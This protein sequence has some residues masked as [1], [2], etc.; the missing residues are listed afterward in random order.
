MKIGILGTRGIPNHYGGFEQFTEFLSDGL[1][2]KGHEVVVYNSSD[3]PYQE[4]MWNGV[5]IQHCKDWEGK[6]GTVG[7]FFYDL[8]CIRNA[9]KQ[10]FDILLQ[11]GYTS[12]SVWKNLLPKKA[13]IVTN[14]DG[15]EWKRSKFSKPV[16]QFL[17]KAEKWAIE[18]SDHLIADSKG[19]QQYLNQ[20]HATE[21]TYIAY[22]S[23]LFSDSNESY[24]EGYGVEKSNY[25]MLIAR[26]EPE[27]NVEVILDGVV[28]SKNS[29]PFLVVGNT[30]N[31]FGQYLIDKFKDNENIQFIGGVYDLSA[32][33]NL[34]FFSKLYFHGHSVGGTN[35]S[36]LEAMASSAFIVS[37]KNEFNS[38]VL[39]ASAIYFSTSDDISRIINQPIMPEKRKSFIQLNRN[40]IEELYTWKKIIQSYEDLFLKLAASKH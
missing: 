38:A 6:L 21:S 34:R 9:R 16:Q 10:N 36:L 12:S 8:N 4:K 25:N 15:L 35:P 37:H 11:L 23:H 3:H 26:M 19:I 22:G 39:E 28:Q 33:N 17:K 40:K 14:M 32:L 20:S 31:R 7:Q 27:N 1:V 24:L 29:S 5:C 18:S 30:N 2:K 13:V